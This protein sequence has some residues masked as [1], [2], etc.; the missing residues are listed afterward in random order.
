M[1]QPA[2]L[3]GIFNGQQVAHI[4]H[5][6]D[7][8]LIAPWIVADRAD[9]SIREVMTVFTKTNFIDETDDGFSKSLC[10][11]RWLPEQM[12]HHANRATLANAGQ[13]G[14][15]INSLFEYLGRK[16]IH[17]AKIRFIRRY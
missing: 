8:A 7:Y 1:I 14:K 3:I 13:G 17:L 12:Q 5:Y 4:F 16:G 15:L 9:F 11:M 10:F 2:I 6:T